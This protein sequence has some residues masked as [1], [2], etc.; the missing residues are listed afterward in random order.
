MAMLDDLLPMAMRWMHMV[1]MALLGGGIAF[2]ISCVHPV[3]T[4]LEPETGQGMMRLVRGRFLRLMWLAM[5]GLALSGVYNW[6]MT[7]G[8]YR[9]MG[10]V[11]NALIGA[12]V[13]VALILFLL[14]W[15]QALGLIGKR[16]TRAWLT[17]HLCLTLI[18]ILLGVMLRHHRLAHLLDAAG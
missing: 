14:I 1:C 3:A 15:A 4:A 2:L 6:V 7:A 16:R 17:V 5:A 11:G 9:A 13:L 8:T 12:K 18:V 10:P